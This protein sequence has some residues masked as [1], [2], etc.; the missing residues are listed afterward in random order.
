MNIF[1]PDFNPPRGFVT[2]TCCCFFT[3][4][5]FY[6]SD[7]EAVISS[8]E[9]LRVWSD[10]DWPEDDFTAEINRRELQ[11]HVD[12]NK[13]HE[14][15]GYMLYDPTRTRCFGSLYVNPTE[16]LEHYALELGSAASLA[17][18]DARIDY[19]LSESCVDLHRQL[20]ATIYQW[21]TRDWPIRA[22]FTGRGAARQTLYEQ[23][24][25]THGHTLCS[26]ETGTRLYLYQ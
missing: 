3:D 24:D 16:S 18:L 8:R 15:Y 25:M 7:F 11:F 22:G 4:P 19:W 6:L 10:S 20:S 26:L 9:S 14:A 1:T 5:D 17:R 2:A 12:D 13:A 21:I 23:I